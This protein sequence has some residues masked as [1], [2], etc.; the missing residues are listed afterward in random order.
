MTDS[1]ALVPAEQAPLTH[2]IF[3]CTGSAC[4]NNGSAAV[5]EA[6]YEQ[7]AAKG[8]LFG[9]RGSMTGS[10]L[11]TQCGSMGLCTV[12]PA[13]L[14][15]PQG[16]WYKGVTPQDV[17]EIIDHHIVGGQVVERLFSRTLG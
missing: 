7:L 4:S 3:V 12:G 8:L 13:V 17:A 5:L 14:I 10:V 16:V 9:K 6:F 2:H 11:V 1:C 15:Y